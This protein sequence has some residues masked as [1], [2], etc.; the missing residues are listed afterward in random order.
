MIIYK[1]LF[2][3]DEMFCD[4]FKVELLH[5]CLYKV[6]GTLI[7]QDCG[8]DE[9]KFG[10]NAS[11]DGA[12][13]DEGA[14]DGVKYVIDV[15]DNHKLTETQFAK[16]DYQTYIKGYMKRVKTKLT[17]DGSDQLDVF[18]NSAPAAVKFLLGKFK[19]LCFFVGCSMDYDAMIPLM[20]S[21]DEKT[22]AFYF[23]KHGLIEEKV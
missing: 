2:S 12:D 20:E 1:D 13:A 22:S 23:F 11:A 4:S 3:G 15:V 7:K 21:I 17:D 10:F 14:E 9:S 18:T 16:K 19:D 5:G 8:V 6:T